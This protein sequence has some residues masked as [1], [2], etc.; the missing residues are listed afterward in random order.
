MQIELSAHTHT[1]A[2]I[3]E[4][5]EKK[6]MNFYYAWLKQALNLPYVNG[7][8]IVGMVHEN[9]KR[10]FIKLC[11]WYIAYCSVWVQIIFNF[12]SVDDTYPAI[13]SGFLVYNTHILVLLPFHDE[14]QH[15][16]T[17][18]FDIS[19]SNW[20]FHFAEDAYIF[21]FDLK[22]YTLSCYGGGQ[23]KLFISTYKF[24]IDDSLYWEVD[25]KGNKIKSY[26]LP[27]HFSRFIYLF[28]LLTDI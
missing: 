14:K 16:F 5:E 2:F 6:R 24:N 25:K 17:I 11:M 27:I 7:G 26:Q 9:L 18:G 19:S 12:D 20:I 3:R 23:T 13:S 22:Q 4:K 10:P 21:K 8:G 1:H 28:I 15:W